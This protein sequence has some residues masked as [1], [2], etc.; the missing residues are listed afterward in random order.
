MATRCSSK[1]ALPLW[2]RLSRI[3]LCLAG[4]ILSVYALYVEHMKERNDGYTAMCDVNDEISCSKVFTSKYGK[5]FG[6]VG[7]ILGEDSPLNFPNSIFGIVFYF[8]Q[9]TLGQIHTVDAVWGL[10]FLSVCSIFG[11]IY[12]AYILMFVLQDACI[13]CISTYIVNALLLVLNVLKLN[14]VKRLSIKKRK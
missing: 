8:L 4:L 10:I 9:F 7:P 13:V 2:H 6:L 3:F 1:A 5:G 12:L 14:V 11:C